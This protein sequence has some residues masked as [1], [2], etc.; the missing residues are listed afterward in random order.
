MLPRNHSSLDSALN[1]L[2]GQ[3]HENGQTHPKE[4]PDRIIIAQ[5]VE[6]LLDLLFP[7]HRLKRHNISETLSTIGRHIFNLLTEQVRIANLHREE[8][9]PTPEHGV[10]ELFEVMPEIRRKLMEDMQAAYQGDPAARGP[11]EVIVSYPTTVATGTYRLA[12]ELHRRKIPLIPRMMTE[13]A[14]RLTG[15]D[16]HPGATIGRSFFIDHGTG[17]VIGETTEIGDRVRLYQGVTLGAA[18]FRKDEHGQL[19]RGTKRHPT[20]EDDV[21]VYANATIL[22]G[23]TVIGARSVIGSNAWLTESVAPDSVVTSEKPELRIRAKR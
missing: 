2:S 14:H 16:I 17:V 5:T 20:L 22:G 7:E 18:N 4:F 12:H 6:S 13:Y 21:I 15:I 3:Y 8:P 10:L 11:D 23:D 1:T 19:I 9:S